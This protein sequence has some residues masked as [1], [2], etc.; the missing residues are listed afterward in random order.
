MD[1]GSHSGLM[2][3]ICTILYADDFDVEIREYS[4]ATWFGPS[5]KV[6]IF[7]DNFHYFISMIE[8]SVI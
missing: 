1:L 4:L 8:E 2:E 6:T 3:I 7:R 5:T